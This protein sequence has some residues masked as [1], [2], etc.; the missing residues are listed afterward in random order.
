M[1]KGT[2]QNEEGRDIKLAERRK[3]G[4]VVCVVAAARETAFLPGMCIP[5]GRSRSS[6]VRELASKNSRILA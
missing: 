6:V 5:P 4:E 3:K 1:H 2:C